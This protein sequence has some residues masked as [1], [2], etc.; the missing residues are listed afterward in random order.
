MTAAGGAAL[1]LDLTR[2]V[3]RVGGGR[4]TGVD[5]VELA[6][7][8]G[9]LRRPRTFFALVRAAP[10][11]VLL[12]RDGAR[13]LAAR[14]TGAAD[15]GTPDLTALLHLRQT[16]ARRRAMADLR[17]LA[18]DRSGPVAPVQGLH[19]LLARHLPAGTVWLAT[20]HSNLSHEVF[21]AVQALP[22][23]RA[24]VMIHDTIPLDHPEFSRPEA[25]A[26]F[27]RRFR[28]AGARAD[29][30]IYNSA[31]TRHAAEAHFAAAGRVPPAL[32]AH[33]G[34]A[35]AAPGRLPAGLDPGRPCFLALGTIEPRKNHALLLDLWEGFAALPAP[36]RPVL[37]I[38]GRRGWA[39]PG[40]LSRLDARPPDVLELN[41][42]DD[43][44]VSALMRHARALLF[45]SHAEGFG[46]PASEAAAMGLPVVAGDLPVLR[47]VLGDLPRLIPVTDRDA[48][49]RTILALADPDT[50]PPR[51]APV[52]VP[53]W[54]AHLNHVL[55]RL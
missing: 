9:L 44:T 16:P 27:A 35:P 33:L 48:W 4:P 18:L 28:L 37:V 5:R 11:F 29:L 49:H 15:W 46:L 26:T 43:A 45:P 41:D 19:R 3:S 25:A 50:A 1:L 39:G 31:V 13:A 47:E 6:W 21:D 52:A 54:D 12:D 53:G 24:A 23:G 51:P 22:G 30:A 10:G 20:G 2:V 8:S 14:L 55:N 40:L 32:V 42:P 7:L 34:A 38:A 17:R 36:Q